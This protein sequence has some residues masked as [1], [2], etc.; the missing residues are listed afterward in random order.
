MVAQLPDD[1]GEPVRIATW[2]LVRPRLPGPRLSYAVRSESG[3]FASRTLTTQ[4][5]FFERG[6]ARSQPRSGTHRHGSL[7][8][9]TSA[10]SLPYA[11]TAVSATGRPSVAA[12]ARS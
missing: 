4:G 7:P 2:N 6:Y 11:S 9:P 5:R 3:C 8:L 1:E 12:A 10:V